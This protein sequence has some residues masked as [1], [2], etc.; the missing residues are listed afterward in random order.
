M[1]IL[2]FDIEEWYCYQLKDYGTKEFY[3]PILDQL[4]GDLLDLLDSRSF[5]ATFFCVGEI[6]R[7]YPHIIKKIAERGH[8][9]GCHSNRHR[10]LTELTYK[11]LQSDTKDAITALENTIG[12]KVRSYR[13]PAFSIGE[14]NKWALE[15]LAENGIECDSSIFPA[16]RDFGGF[17]S[18]TEKKP[19]TIIYKGIKLKEFP[20]G[21]INVFGKEM[22]YSGGG[23]FRMMPY[24]LTKRILL[25]SEYGI[26]YLH[27]RDFD[28]SQKKKIN[29]R[30][31]KNYYGV[32][33]AYNKLCQLI[34]DFD[35]INIDKADK[36]INWNTQRQILL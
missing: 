1:Y 2:T 6:A 22:A 4:L 24:A 29:R 8:E 28:K 33:G 7:E 15:I 17:P 27:I 30:Y 21:T 23:Y 14:S 11:E 32:D 13:A 34:L 10:W 36:N 12:K 31:F 35:F 3:L 9:I 26:V 19:V 18:F 25:K 20:I 16:S 5:T